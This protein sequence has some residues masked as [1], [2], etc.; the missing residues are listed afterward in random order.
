MDYR[1]LGKTGIQVSAICLGTAF[2]GQTDENVCIRTIDRALDLGCNFID[3]ALYGNGKSE[4]LLGRALKGKR[5]E[6]V[7]CTKV[8]GTLG[9]SPTHNGLTRINI[10]R[11][12]EASLKRLQT[13]HLDL[14]LLHSYDPKA[15]VEEIVRTLDDLVRQGKVRYVGCSNWPV[16]KVVEALWIS[17][18]RNLAPF[19][20]L[21]YQYS[22][23]NR[24]EF[25]PELAPLCLDFGLGSMT[26]S[27]LA[28]GLLSGRFRRGVAPPADSPWGAEPAA[29]LSRTKYPFAEAMTEQAD[30]VV[31]ALID[32]GGKYGKT[33][34]QVAV[35][36]VLDH[37]EV[38][39]PILGADNP[40]Q[41]DEVFG[42]T[43]WALEREDR[44]NLDEL[45]APRLA[46]KFS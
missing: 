12:V 25:E 6:V 4:Q 21:Q 20:C 3:T 35:A 7:L 30:R 33:A 31:Q 36:W 24:T 16:R 37:P 22:L 45:S 11:G 32:L 43:G 9:S 14:Y 44:A 27:P 19:V 8:Y 1:Y 2:R 28:I 38:T 46:A 40:E 15:P 29:G 18:K 42:A 26:Y 39:A 23:L 41:V 10:L 17:D 34:A 5:D 13:D